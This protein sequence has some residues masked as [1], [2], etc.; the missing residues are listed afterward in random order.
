MITQTTDFEGVQ[1]LL[2]EDELVNAPMIRLL[3]APPANLEIWL[4]SMPQSSGVLFIQPPQPGTWDAAQYP[5]CW[6]RIWIQSL[7]TAGVDGLIDRLPSKREFLFKLHRPWIAAHL[8]GRLS[9]EW[10]GGLSY[11]MLIPCDFVDRREHNV[12]ELAAHHIP[13]ATDLFTHP[14][15]TPSA[16]NICPA[17]YG[18]V[19]CLSGGRTY[20]G[21]I[22]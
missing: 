2:Y 10:K 12:I 3:N 9:L 17:R 20:I 7:S 16:T 5:M 22:C 15:R 4:D 11:F 14:G 8:M 6:Q 13:Q 19:W 1:S 21:S 18:R